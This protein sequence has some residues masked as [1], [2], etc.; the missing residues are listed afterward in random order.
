MSRLFIIVLL[1]TVTVQASQLNSYFEQGNVY[2]QNGQYQLAI[3]SY[4]NAI[5]QREESAG[6]YYN[7]GNAY[8]KL[9]KIGRAIL[10]Y[11]RAIRLSPRDPDILYN[12]QIAQ[13]R[14]VDKIETPMPFFLFKLWNDFKR[15]V[16]TDQIANIFLALY[17]LFMTVLL[18]R[19][20]IQNQK[21]E[22]LLRTSFLPLAILV[23]TT[24]TIL[25]FRA[26]SDLRL[27]E[28]VILVDK[29]DVKSSPAQDATEVFALHEGVKVRV[30]D[31]SGKF[32][33]IELP[34]GKVGWVPNDVIELVRG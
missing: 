13:L 30:T 8:F 2:F 3:D 22:R 9:D 7:L 34:D 18:L 1:C 17:V 19:F 25:F 5:K 33:E 16:S 21:V 24:G 6:L 27:K 28:G 15:R 32:V 11:E 4:E 23:L 26:R 14:V 20:V 31:F 10:N 12:L 29:I